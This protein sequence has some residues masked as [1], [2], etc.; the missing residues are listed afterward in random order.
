MCILHLLLVPVAWHL[1]KRIAVDHLGHLDALNRNLI[2]FRWSYHS[3]VG[4]IAVDAVD[5]VAA[6]A[7]NGLV[8]D[9]T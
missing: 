6:V 4:A 9:A 5:A 2:H 3:C 1:T 7:V 8:N